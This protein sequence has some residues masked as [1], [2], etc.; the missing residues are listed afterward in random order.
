[1]NNPIIFGFYCKLITSSITT[2]NDNCELKLDI[3]CIQ[4]RAYCKL[5]NCL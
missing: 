2:S 1:M 4:N 5:G 3:E